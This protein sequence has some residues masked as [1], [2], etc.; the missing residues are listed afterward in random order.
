MGMFSKLDGLMGAVDHGKCAPLFYQAPVAELSC[1]SIDCG[2]YQL[3][4]THDTFNVTKEI[5]VMSSSVLGPTVYVPPGPAPLQKQFWN[6][7]E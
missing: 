7:V 3:F 6:I 5:E 1:L 2:A 4:G